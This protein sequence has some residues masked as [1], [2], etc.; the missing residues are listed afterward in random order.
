MTQA[1]EP[2]PVTENLLRE[3][4]ERIR[5]AGDPLMIVLFGS[6]ARGDS[7]PYS[8]LDILIVEESADP[9]YNRSPKYYSATRHTFPARDIV[10]WTPEEIRAWS[11][12]PNH[13]VTTALREG[14]VIYERPG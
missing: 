7:H 1:E 4:V 5:A 11:A 6:H 12:V 2:A 3:I 13:F 9:R 14:R 8:D 10:V